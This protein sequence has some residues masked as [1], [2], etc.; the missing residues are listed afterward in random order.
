[1]PNKKRE[2]TDEQRKQVKLLSGMGMK[3]DR[4]A[5]V[6]GIPE[7]TLQRRCK[8]ELASGPAVVDG[9]VFSQIFQKIAAG[10]NTMI[11]FYCKTRLRW[12]DTT[13]VELT[14]K[15]GEKLIPPQVIS[16]QDKLTS[17]QITAQLLLTE[18]LIGALEGN[19]GQGKK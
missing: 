13:R 7:A 14:G 9:M 12:V 2:I 10:D 6:V 8:E 4:I 1:M 15:D 5:M 17:E 19:R 11:I 3:Q 18:R 16:S